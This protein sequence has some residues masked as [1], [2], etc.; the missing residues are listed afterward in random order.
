MRRNP[1]AFPKLKPYGR[2]TKEYVPTVIPPQS[3]IQAIQQRLV[4]TFFYDGL[5]REVEPHACG[6]FENGRTVLIGYQ[7]FGLSRSGNEPPWRTFS[8]DEM[9]GLQVTDKRFEHN[10]PGYNPFDA[11]LMQVFARV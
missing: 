4:V 7:I 2:P 9:V 11:R 3:L 1:Y 6:V 10:R 5:S 8:V